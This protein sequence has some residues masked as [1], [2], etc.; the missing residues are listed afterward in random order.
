LPLALAGLAGLFLVQIYRAAL[1]SSEVDAGVLALS[2]M[3]IV[4][5][6]LGFVFGWAGVKAFGMSFG[7]ILI[8]LPMPSTIQGI[9]VGG[10][11]NLV[12]VVDTNLL[13]LMGIPATQVGS[14]IHL[15]EGTVGIDEA[16][17]G[18]R[19][20]QS[21]IMATVFIGYLSLRR[22][23]FQALLLV[24]G[25]ALAF[26]GNLIRSLYLCLTAHAHGMAAVK[27]VHDAAGW[28]ILAFTA[29]GVILISW[30]F[31]RLDQQLLTPAKQDDSRAGGT[32]PS[33]DDEP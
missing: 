14:L 8:A 9:V 29:A 33:S 17:S 6:N 28:S 24:G 21:T 12:A 25:V 31:N 27:E 30:L 2:V 16:C 26:L 3:L 32:P 22:F 4:A 7:F 23:T 19:S 10:L 13:N 11:Q 5:A 18:I 15:S 1:G 20:L